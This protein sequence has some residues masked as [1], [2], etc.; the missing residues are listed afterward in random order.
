MEGSNTDNHTNLN[1]SKQPASGSTDIQPT[2][3]SKQS[4]ST[5]ASGTAKKNAQKDWDNIVKELLAE[6]EEE[7]SADDLFKEIY[8]QGTDEV[9][10]AM[11]KSFTESGGTVLSTN[12]NEVGRGQTSVKPPNGCEF[13]K[14]T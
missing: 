12:W 11:V 9:R 8:S 4:T 10:R 2:S 7:K 3:S 5:V 1:N 14:W 13:K 6:D